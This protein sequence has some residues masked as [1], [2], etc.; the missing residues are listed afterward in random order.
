[1]MEKSADK[2]GPEIVQLMQHWLQDEDFTGVRG[3]NALA[4]LPEAERSAWRKL[5]SDVAEMLAKAQGKASAE[6]K[7]DAK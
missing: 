2:S 7:P 1:M 6:K 3:D 5:W 4:K